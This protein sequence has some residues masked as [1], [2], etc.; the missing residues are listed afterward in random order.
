MRS[1][2]TYVITN[3]NDTKLYTF[4]SDKK[5]IEQFEEDM[6]MS[7]EDINKQLKENGYFLYK[8]KR[9]YLS[10]TFIDYMEEEW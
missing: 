7:I 1:I 3:E 4:V 2:L 9:C 5:S 8:G 10:K 6:N